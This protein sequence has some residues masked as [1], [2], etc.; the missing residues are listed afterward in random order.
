M[1]RPDL[2]AGPRQAGPGTG[3]VACARACVWGGVGVEVGSHT[4]VFPGVV[5]ARGFGKALLP[6]LPAA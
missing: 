5:P 6:R 1:P 3:V 4:E 2:E